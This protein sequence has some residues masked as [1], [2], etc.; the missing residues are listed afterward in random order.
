[1]FLFTSIN[2]GGLGFSPQR[3][4][5]FLAALAASQ[6]LWTLAVFPGLNRKVGNLNVMRLCSTGWPFLFACF[7]VLNE[8][9][10]LGAR[11]AF[12]A[13]LV[14]PLLIGGFVAMS[15]AGAQLLVNEACPSPKELALINALTQ[16][17]LQRRDGESADLLTLVVQTLNSAVR[18]VTPALFTSIFAA[19]VKDQQLH[20]HLCWA[21]LVLLTLPLNWALA[22]RSKRVSLITQS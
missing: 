4:S 21:V 10:R 6:G 18:S 8:L 3:I 7:P 9:L 16:V 20:G 13:A 22:F 14:V 17:C 1:M 2:I 15:F 12:W 11:T 19:G 5:Y